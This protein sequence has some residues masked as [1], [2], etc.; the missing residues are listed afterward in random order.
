MFR[1]K[2]WKKK[3]FNFGFS[4]NFF[5]DKKNSFFLFLPSLSSPKLDGMDNFVAGF[6]FL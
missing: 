3:N 4:K 5:F 1:K 2:K 6:S